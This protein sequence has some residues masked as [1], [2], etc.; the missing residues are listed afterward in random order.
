MNPIKK[1]V[2]PLKE[3]TKPIIQI[4]NS[5]STK[6]STAQAARKV[7]RQFKNRPRFINLD[8]PYVSE[9]TIYT[10]SH[11]SGINANIRI[12]GKCGRP[13]LRKV[14]QKLINSATSEREFYYEHQANCKC[15]T[16][17]LEESLE[18]ETRWTCRM[19]ETVDEVGNIEESEVVIQQSLMRTSIESQTSSGTMLEEDEPEETLPMLGAT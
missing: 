17:T 13:D 2:N 5:L 4:T 16:A 9:V 7:S 19:T 10:E 8:L 11:P 3:L 18:R 15:S 6:I 12:G 1:L 14:H